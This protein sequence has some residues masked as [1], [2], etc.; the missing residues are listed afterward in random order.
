V[1]TQIEQQERRRRRKEWRKQRKR[2][3]AQRKK[4]HERAVARRL[5]RI[6]ELRRLWT[7]IPPKPGD[8]LDEDAACLWAGG[9]KP[10]DPS[11]LRRRYSKPIHIGPQAVRWP[12][13]NL[14]ADRERLNAGRASE[15]TTNSEAIPA[16]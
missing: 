16:E 9:S 7:E 8:L 5:E 6:A 11:T 15:I 13:E 3:K 4:E 12:F 1:S 10:I 2:T 14:Q